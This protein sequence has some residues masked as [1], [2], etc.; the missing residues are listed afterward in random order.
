MCGRL[1]QFAGRRPRGRFFLQ[2]LGIL[3]GGQAGKTAVRARGVVT[4]A[5][6]FD[7]APRIGETEEPVLVQ[8]LVPESA[9]ETLDEGVLHRLPRPDEA[10]RYS[11]AVCPRIERSTLKLGPG[12]D[13]DP[14]GKP[15]RHRQPLEH[16]HHTLTAQT[17]LHCDHRALARAGVDE[18]HGAER[19]SASVSR[20]QSIAH[21]SF[22][23]VAAG[24]T[25]RGTATRLRRCRRTA[26]PS[27]RSSRRIHCGLDPV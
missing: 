16:R 9:I 7:R 4:D 19:P 23:R 6:R 1:D 20:M 14:L 24:T 21:C 26:R 8:A 22:A 3:A 27:S 11:P 17:H 13:D 5:P 25:T 18:R 2:L 12:V 10:Q 15:T